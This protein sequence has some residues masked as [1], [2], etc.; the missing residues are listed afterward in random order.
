M[1]RQNADSMKEITDL[2][3]KLQVKH[4]EL[5][6]YQTENDMLEEKIQEL[7]DLSKIRDRQMRSDVRLRNCSKLV[8]CTKRITGGGTGLG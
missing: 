2:R 4:K 6:D 8:K 3:S 7:E 1:E 5:S